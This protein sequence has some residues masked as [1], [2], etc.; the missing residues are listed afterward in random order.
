MTLEALIF[1]VDGTLA[2]TEEAHRRAFNAAFRAHGLDWDWHPAL[3][4]ELLRVA[5]GKER[6]LHYIGRLDLHETKSRP[7]E[8]AAAEIHQT[9]TRRYT[10]MVEGGQVPLRAGVARLLAEAREAGFKLAIATTTSA[11]NVEALITAHFGTRGLE[12]FGV[13]ACGDA[14]RSKKP[15]PDI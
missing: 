15:A 9:K 8:E 4:R 6:I 11:P 3:Y 5:G 13:I 10:A 2:D 1:D 12:L 7:L 14:V